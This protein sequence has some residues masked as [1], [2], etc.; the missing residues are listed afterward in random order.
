[1]F[2]EAKWIWYDKEGT[3]NSFGEFYSEFC[4]PK[5]TCKISCDGDYTLFINGKF[6]AS[7]QYGDFEHYKSVDEINLTP[8]LKDG[9]NI[10]AIL[11]WHFGK[12]SQRY[13]KYTPGLICEVLAGDVVVFSTNEDTLCRKSSAYECGFDREITSQLGF[14][15]KYD[16]TKEDL[17]VLGQGKSFKKAYPVDKKCDFVPRPNKRLLLESFVS[18]HLV[19]E[20]GNNYL[21][22]LGREYVGLLSF[23]L[24]AKDSGLINISYGECLENGHV[25]RKIGAR[26]FCVDYVASAGENSYTNYM[27]RF[28]CRYIEIN[29]EKPLNIKKIG[30]IP[31]YYPVKEKAFDFLKGEDYEIYKACI[32]TLKLCMM[33]H[34]VD[35]PW[36]EQCLYAFDSRNQML[37]GYCAFEKGNFHYARSNLLL[38]S[39]DRRNDGLLSI[40]YPCGIDL[41]IPSFSL[42]YI[43]AIKEY[44][45]SSGD[46]QI[47]NDVND[48]LTEIIHTFLGNCKNGLVCTFEN[49]CHWNFYDWSPHSDGYIERDRKGHP[50]SMASILTVLALNS[51]KK[52]C[53]LCT[54]PFAFEEKITELK[55][56]IISAFYDCEKQIFTSYSQPTE[57]VNALAVVAKVAVGDMAK[58]ICR[59]LCAREL[60]PC[61]L[62]MKAF[63]YDALLNTDTEKYEAFVLNDIRTSYSPM[64]ETGTVWETAI[65]HSDFGNAGSLCHGWSST[66]IYYYWKLLK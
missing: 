54:L 24:E 20:E 47:I 40:C 8:Y 11:V 48:K 53:E 28:A 30:L 12:D 50:D 63:V 18:S 55:E 5:A 41:T 21:Y 44:I 1:M 34:Y 61:S 29:S 35:C 46:A 9:K 52:I 58:E 2:K 66:P 33:E 15:Y 19:T 14:S 22:D 37:S 32:N 3:Q 23:E 36:R 56:N 27:L 42:Y 38:M 64:T 59:K 62:S 4:A 25:K 45:E 17:W 57:L 39:K 26:D 16:S 7:N 51:Y 10:I 43:L 49:D 65:G 6:A 60:I 31:Q 13:K